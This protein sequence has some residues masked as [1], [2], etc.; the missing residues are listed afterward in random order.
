MA[1]S[2]V[3]EWGCLRVVLLGKS[4]VALLDQRR[5]DWTAVQTAHNLVVQSVCMT[6][7][8]WAVKKVV[9]R[10]VSWERW[11]ADV[12]AENWVACLEVMTAAL[13]AGCLAEQKGD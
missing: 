11:S 10:A 5:V 8:K 13:T 2:L 4:L 1:A 6:V 7:V 12:L 3:A 9:L